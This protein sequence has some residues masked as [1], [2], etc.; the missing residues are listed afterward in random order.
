MKIKSITT[1]ALTA[2]LF[3][4]AL[5]T[6]GCEKSPEDKAAD[7]IGDAKDAVKDATN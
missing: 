6:T 5:M 2:L 1:L 3:A 7:A 4:G